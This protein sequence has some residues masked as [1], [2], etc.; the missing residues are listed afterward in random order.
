[1]RGIKKAVPIIFAL[2]VA[3]VPPLTSQTVLAKEGNGKKIEKS[4][5]VSLEKAKNAVI[6]YV[7]TVAENSYENWKDAKLGDTSDLYDFDGNLTAYLFPVIVNGED[8]GYVIYG[9]NEGNGG[10][11]ESTREGEH[12]YSG[13]NESERIYVGPL[14][15]YKKIDSGEFEDLHS[16]K[17]IQ[18]EDLLS[19]GPLSQSEI[20]KRLT[21]AEEELVSPMSSP[22]N[23][24]YKLIRSVPD[25]DWYIGCTPT[26]A[27][28]IISYFDD[29]GY[30][31][32]VSN[33]TSTKSLI[34][35]LASKDYMRTGLCK[36]CSKDATSW[37][38]TIEGIEAY[39][40]DKGY[41][42]VSVRGYNSG[43]RFSKHQSAMDDDRPDIIWLQRHPTYGNHAVTG[44]G[45]EEYQDADDDLRYYRSVIIHD[46]W[47]NTPKDCWVT[48][49]S[50]TFTGVITVTP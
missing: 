6:K 5:V 30:S 34:S 13:V 3:M 22:V 1:M 8:S 29:N 9:V 15:H 31:K 46:T 19:E 48:W 38:D 41:K 36:G 7:E 37:D 45:Y 28:N 49:D 42:D 43:S 40:N 20:N 35:T 26:S 27:A 47:S 21:V 50:S 14:M 44:V 23:Y 2:S 4:S 16:K 39:W 18:E 25:Y 11:L 12:P 24:S 10:I 32:L 17:V 33:N